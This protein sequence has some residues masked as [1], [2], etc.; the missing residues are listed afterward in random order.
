[1]NENT[2]RDIQTDKRHKKESFHNTFTKKNN[3]LII[4]QFTFFIPLVLFQ[5]YCSMSGL[6]RL[7]QKD[8][9]FE[10]NVRNDEKEREIKWMAECEWM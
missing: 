1:M 9:P 2:A 6:I 8:H 3:I 5:S 4:S 10:W 7:M